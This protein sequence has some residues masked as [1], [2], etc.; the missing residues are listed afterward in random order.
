MGSSDQGR[1]ARW[2]KTHCSAASCTGRA[3]T[4]SSA[5]SHHPGRRRS[6]RQCDACPH[7]L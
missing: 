7:V 1:G 4:R 2:V 3:R 5:L 6:A